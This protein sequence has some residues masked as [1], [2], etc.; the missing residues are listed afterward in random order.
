M[1]LK[2]IQMLIARWPPNWNNWEY[3]RDTEIDELENVFK[4]KIIYFDNWNNLYNQ[5]PKFFKKEKIMGILLY[6]SFL[7]KY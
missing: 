3:Q 4:N 1:L 2:A 7:A 6:D 5:W